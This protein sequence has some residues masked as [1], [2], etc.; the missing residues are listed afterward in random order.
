MSDVK[1]KQLIRAYGDRRDDGII[2]LSFT[3]LEALIPVD[4][5]PTANFVH[6]NG[7]SSFLSSFFLPSSL[8]FLLN[9]FY[10]KKIKYTSNRI[11]EKDNLF[12]ENSPAIFLVLL[13]HDKSIYN[14]LFSLFLSFLL[15]LI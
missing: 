8:S 10:I 5:E 6:T 4:S 15:Y 3:L 12:S 1:P 14:V 2:Q 11:I 13:H 9:L 7:I